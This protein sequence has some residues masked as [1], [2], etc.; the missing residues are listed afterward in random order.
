MKITKRQLK[1]IIR[2]EKQKLLEGGCGD[3][4][5]VEP[6]TLEKEPEYHDMSHVEESPCPY[7]TAD[8]LKAAGMSEVEV[9]EWVNNM[10]SSF[11]SEGEFSYTGDVED[12]P[13]DEAFGVGYQAGS[14]GL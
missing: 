5:A 8:K 3:M 6:L 1:R 4:S 11:L 7:S 10:I 14:L 9:L 2:E 12:L 13:G